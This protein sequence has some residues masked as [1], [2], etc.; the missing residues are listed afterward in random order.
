MAKFLFDLIK[1]LLLAGS[2]EQ[3]SSITS[4]YPIDLDRGL[5]KHTMVRKVYGQTFKI[6]MTLLE[7]AYIF[8]YFGIVS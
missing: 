7:Y 1:V 8:N 2:R 3:G 6:K 5:N 4:L